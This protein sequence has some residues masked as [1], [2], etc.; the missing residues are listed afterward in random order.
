[1][2]L[3]VGAT[4]N[5]GRHVVRQLLERG[6]AVRAMTRELVRASALREAGAEVVRGDLRDI[7]SLRAAMRGVQSVVSSAHAIMGTGRDSSARVDDDGQRALIVAARDE[8]V[9]QF[10]FVSAMGASALHPVDF[11][12]TK[13]RIERAVAASGLP[14]TIIRPSAYMTF[15]AY[16]LLGKAVMSGG[17]VVLFGAGD[18]PRNF[19]AE[20]D[21]ARLVV[22]AFVDD[23]LRGEVIEI[24]G[25]ENLSSAEVVATFE[26]ISGRQARVIH[27]PLGVLRALARFAPP[28][29][30]G[31]TRA[32]QAIVHA[33]TA[34]QR[35]DPGPLLARFPMTLQPLEDWARAHI[36][37]LGSTRA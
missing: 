18:N 9:G 8:G 25:P 7:G 23:R 24:G 19:V 22:R 34:E 12:R 11:W 27:F 35:F 1:M 32:L 16:E 30:Q 4:G 13:E 31:V 3:V 28:V 20:A 14:Y 36:G 33:E 21:V 15:H 5:L 10:V 6:H 17:R 2:I 29:H 26:R 37:A